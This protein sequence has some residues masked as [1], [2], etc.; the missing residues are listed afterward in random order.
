MCG[1]NYAN[2]ETAH[3]I[4]ANLSV[5]NYAQKAIARKKFR[6]YS[7]INF[8]PISREKLNVKNYATE[9]FLRYMFLVWGE[10]LTEKPSEQNYIACGLHPLV[11]EVTEY[12]Y[13]YSYTTMDGVFM[14][15]YLQFYQRIVSVN[16]FL[17]LKPLFLVATDTVIGQDKDKKHLHVN[18]ERFSFYICVRWSYN[19]PQP[20]VSRESPWPSNVSVLNSPAIRSNQN[21]CVPS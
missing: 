17:P 1:C 8:E 18:K 3:N 9:L 13:H 19:F 7:L 11:V 20:R 4:G 12:V 5:R 21:N 6:L 2:R 16:I 15:L 10:Y 14:S